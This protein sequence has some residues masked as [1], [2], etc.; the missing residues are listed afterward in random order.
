MKTT[1]LLSLIALC[2][3]ARFSTTQTDISYEAGLPSRS[4]TTEAS[5]TT[6]AAS[7]S[8]LANWKAS[9]TDKTQ[10]AS[11]AQLNQEAD[12]SKLLEALTRAAIDQAVK[13]TT[14]VP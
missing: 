1:I 8:A 10:G 13:S 9:Q 4:I 7:K 11:V 6:F 12:S 2:G 3:C 5:A 14:P